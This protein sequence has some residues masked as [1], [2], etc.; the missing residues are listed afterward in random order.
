MVATMWKNV[1]GATKVTM[2]LHQGLS[3]ASTATLLEQDNVRTFDLS[4]VAVKEVSNPMNN[5]A[6]LWLK[7]WSL[8][9]CAKKVAGGE[10]RECVVCRRQDSVVKSTMG[11][12]K[13]RQD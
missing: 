4:Q 6:G 12:M 9:G 2:T 13:E 7:E 10:Q 5:A 11:G 1:S 8:T 3:L